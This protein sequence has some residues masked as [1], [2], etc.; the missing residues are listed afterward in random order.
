[1]LSNI[2][3]LRFVAALMVVLYHTAAHVLDSRHELGGLFGIG[4]AVGFAGVDVFFVISG[5]IMAWTTVGDAG[6]PAAISFIKRRVARVYSGYWPFYLLALVL[7]S[8]LGGQYLANAQLLRSVLLWPTELQYLLIPV[9]W[10][11]IFE[12]FFYLLF[13]SLIAFSSVHRGLLVK[14][15][16]LAMLGWSVYSHFVRHAYDPGQLES[17]SLYEQYTIFPFLLEFLAGSILA[18]WLRRHPKGHA[19]PLLLSGMALLLVSGWINSAQFG[20]KL[21]EG[22]FILWRVLLFGG[23][24]VLIVAGLVRLENLGW[25]VAPRFSLLAG[26]ASYALYLSHTL[27]LAA[28]ERMGLNDWLSHYPGWMA[29]AAFICLAALIALYSIAHYRWVERSLHRAFRRWLRV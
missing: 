26:G 3:F 5:F 16:A 14:L 9:S 2:Q 24:S 25:T 23:A 13:T 28:T 1:M 11:L 12:M 10:T 21:I 4:Q 6:G 22:Y 19:W 7:F 8:V 20:G 18:D 17:M 27:I 29:R 15:L